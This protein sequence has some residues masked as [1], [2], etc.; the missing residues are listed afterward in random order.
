MNKSFR[1]LD[2]TNRLF[3][4]DLSWAAAVLPRINHAWTEWLDHV[5]WEHYVVATIPETMSR[6]KAALVFK[7]YSCKLEQMVQGRIRW[8]YTVRRGPAGW[9]LYGL[10]SGTAGLS[11]ADLHLMWPEGS[12]H[13]SE[14]DA[15]LGREF[16]LPQMFGSIRLS[17]AK[18]VEYDLQ[19]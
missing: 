16:Y 15:N 7:Q 13:V 10:L 8:F 9:H 17:D 11:I 5:T 1:V 3:N 6:P 19:A 12:L 2:V 14:F 4:A 18:A